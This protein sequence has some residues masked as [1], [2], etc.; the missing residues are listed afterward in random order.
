LGPAKDDDKLAFD[1]INKLKS[2]LEDHSAVEKLLKQPLMEEGLLALK[3]LVEVDYWERVWVVQEVM[4]AYEILVF[5]GKH[6]A[7]CEAIENFQRCLTINHLDGVFANSN[8]NFPTIWM[9]L[10]VSDPLPLLQVL[11]KYRSCKATD[12]RDR[13]LALLGI[14]NFKDS[15]FLTI[16]HSLSVDQMYVNVFEHIAATTGDLNILCSV[17]S[18]KSRPKL[19]SWAPNWTPPPTGT[20]YWIRRDTYHAGISTNMAFSVD[21]TGEEYVLSAKSS[22]IG[23]TLSFASFGTGFV[24]IIPALAQWISFLILNQM[25]NEV[26]QADLGRALLLDQNAQ[27]ARIHEVLG[28]VSKLLAVMFPSDPGSRWPAIYETELD[29]NQALGVGLSKETIMKLLLPVLSGLFTKRLFLL[30]SLGTKLMG[31]GFQTV[32]AGDKICVL[33]GCG[34][35]VILRQHKDGYYI[36]MGCAFISEF[37]D[38]QT[39]A[40]IG[41]GYFNEETFEIH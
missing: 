39:A 9:P 38:G 31:F 24:S 4:A 3:R 36:F 21:K 41:Q 15:H 6:T 23:A 11:S 2:Y 27:L 13:V 8:L 34:M 28:L 32:A 37:M 18:P 7:E 35:P 19:P 30:Q 20:R 1:M 29:K 14:T 17:G 25:S 10:G 22:C 16:D 33:Y 5:R 26:P 40:G 12:P